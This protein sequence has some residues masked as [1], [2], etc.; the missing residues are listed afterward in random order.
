MGCDKKKCD[1]GKTCPVKKKCGSD[2]GCDKQ[3]TTKKETKS[4]D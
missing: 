4:D 1:K 3:D 2:D